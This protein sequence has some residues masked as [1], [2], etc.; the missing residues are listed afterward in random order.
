MRLF[1]TA[2]DGVFAGTL[3]SDNSIALAGDFENT[4][5]YGYPFTSLYIRQL[6]PYF[7]NQLIEA[8][9][10]A[11]VLWAMKHRSMKLPK[12]LST[13]YANYIQIY[14]HHGRMI[15]NPTYPTA[16]L[17]EGNEVLAVTD[18]LVL[19]YFKKILEL[20]AYARSAN[21][22]GMTFDRATIDLRLVTEDSVL[23]PIPVTNE[24]TE[25]MMTRTR[26]INP[27]VGNPLARAIHSISE[28][29]LSSGSMVGLSPIMTLNDF[30]F[31]LG[32]DIDLTLE[33][34]ITETVN[35]PNLT[36]VSVRVAE[37][38]TTF[39]LAPTMSLTQAVEALSFMGVN[40]SM[41]SHL[42]DFL[43]SDQFVTVS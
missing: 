14:N 8:H 5:E 33:K 29:E 22:L 6:G 26:R 18:T 1:S 35:R 7:I 24:W 10:L 42:G 28:I 25:S 9:F 32:N 16:Y 21:E 15:T 30:F 19:D 39:G 23:G 12:F 2:I 37:L 36:D 20:L 13:N 38:T 17:T 4:E 41:D 34:V 31:A 3:T 27:G 11:S 43:S 40:I